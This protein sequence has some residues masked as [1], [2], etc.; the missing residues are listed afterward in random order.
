MMS[1][2]KVD[3]KNNFL[4]LFFW[5]LCSIAFF[6][7]AYPNSI[8]S[9]PV[10]IFML[11][12]LLNVLIFQKKNYAKYIYLLA[13]LGY[14]AVFYWL[15]YPCY[16]YGQIPL[17]VSCCFPVLLGLYLG[18]YVLLYY[19]IVR[20]AKKYLSF[21]GLAFFAA[22][23]WMALEIIREFFLTGFPWPDLALICAPYPYLIQI[24][25]FIGAKGL[26]FCIIFISFLIIKKRYVYLSTGLIIF[27]IIIN[28]FLLH[29]RTGV[30]AKLKSALIQ[31]SIDQEHKWDPKYQLFTLNTYLKLSQKAVQQGARF[32]VW[33][34]TCMPFYFQEN[35]FL[36]NKIKAFARKYKVYLLFGSPGYKFISNTKYLLFNRA[37]LIDTKGKVIGFY[38]KQKLVPFGEY[39]PCKF[40]SSIFGFFYKGVGT[41]SSGTSIEPLKIKKLA[42]G[43]LICYEIIFS[44]LVNQRVRAGAECLVNISNDAWFGHTSGPYQHLYLAVLRAVEQRRFL[45]RCTNS[46]ISAFVSS[47]G[48]ILKKLDLFKRNYLIGDLGVSQKKSFFCRYF[49]FIYAFPFLIIIF[50]FLK[51]IFQGLGQEND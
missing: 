10:F 39:L 20:W 18:G 51:I 5:S 31:A 36:S 16:R 4:Q 14:S 32:I 6:F 1:L 40:L 24:I 49:Y 43:V 33:P 44:H 28:F 41:F 50:M 22:C 48:I 23:L 15:Y 30:F 34:E 38:D 13:S 47:K 21:L 7:F 29:Y 3:C 17:I 37:Y 26:A 46:G 19:L 45:L 8:Y 35:N 2:N 25:Q 9:N 11:L 42:L 12:I 27:F